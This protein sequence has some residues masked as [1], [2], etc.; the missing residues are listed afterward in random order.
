MPRVAGVHRWSGRLALLVTTPIVFHCVFILGFQTDS[1]RVA[2]HSIVGSFLYGVFAVK[3][4]FVR[5]HHF[6]PSWVLPLADS[7]LTAAVIDAALAS[8]GKAIVLVANALK[9]LRDQTN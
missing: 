8:A 2:I 4:L 7:R 6:Y 5:D 3:V 9:L 1:T